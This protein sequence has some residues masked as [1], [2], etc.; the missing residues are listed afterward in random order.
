LGRFDNSSASVAFSGGAAK[1]PHQEVLTTSL[2]AQHATIRENMEKKH[3][4]T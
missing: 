1:E 4:G 3:R 2:T